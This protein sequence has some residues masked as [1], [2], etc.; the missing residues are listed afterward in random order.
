MREAQGEEP[1]TAKYFSDLLSPFKIHY[2]H[3]LY[4]LINYSVVWFTLSQHPETVVSQQSFHSAVIPVRPFFVW[5]Q[6]TRNVLRNISL[7]HNLIKYAH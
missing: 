7:L 2:C 3:S 4:F 6:Q 5:A 1:C